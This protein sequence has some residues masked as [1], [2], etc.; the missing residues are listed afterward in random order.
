VPLHELRQP[1]EVEG[2]AVALCDLGYP[3]GIRLSLRRGEVL[4]ELLEV[5]LEARW[6]DDLEDSSRLIRRVP[7]GVQLAV[8]ELARVERLT[9]Y[10][11][12]PDQGALFTGCT[13]L[14]S[15]VTR[16]PTPL[17]WRPIRHP[18]QRLRTAL[19]ELFAYYRRNR[20]LLGNLRRDLEALPAFVANRLAGASGRSAD[21]LIDGWGARGSKRR[22]LRTALRH[23]VE[24]ET[25]RSLSQ[26]GELTDAEA[27]EDGRPGEAR[28]G[29][30]GQ[31]EPNLLYPKIRSARPQARV[32]THSAGP[33][34]PWCVSS[35]VRLRLGL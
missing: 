24:Y 11:H 10:R 21:L 34:S 9:V 18:E 26:D 14:P 31:T 19:G 13:S 29:V 25:W 32:P 35:N 27:I 22:R 8:E 15:S 3:P 6:R 4:T 20:R 12:F 1:R 16:L 2:E 5:V 23:A 30:A 28:C 33:G 17:S 7:E